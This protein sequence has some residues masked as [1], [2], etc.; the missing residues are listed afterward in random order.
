MN[1]IAQIQ[2]PASYWAWRLGCAWLLLGVMASGLFGQETTPKS[3]P[4]DRVPDL[5]KPGIRPDVFYMKNEKGEEVL[6]PRASY[7]A[8]ERSL[9]DASRS[10]TE[11]LAGIGLTALDLLVEPDR[12]YAKVK[13][14]GRL[15]L[16]AEMK[17]WFSLPIALGQ[18][19]WIPSPD[20]P[21]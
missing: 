8:F 20:R 16:P 13:V 7:E 3:M 6:I 21:Q 15:S 11:N 19:Q 1:R 10:T 18:L 17:S 5:L 2:T 9:I 12:E 14:N 4:P